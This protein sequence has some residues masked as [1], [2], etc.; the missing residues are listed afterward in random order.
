MPK[1]YDQNGNECQ[2]TGLPAMFY[3]KVA[4]D[5]LL[6][7]KSNDYGHEQ[8]MRRQA[9]RR[10]DE[11]RAALASCVAVLGMQ[12]DLHKVAS[13]AIAEANKALMGS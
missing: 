4:V 13:D 5:E 7:E 1:L 2:M 6:V 9:E 8:A 12:R 11:M 10:I 3:D